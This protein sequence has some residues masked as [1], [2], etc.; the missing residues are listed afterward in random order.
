MRATKNAIGENVA[1]MSGAISGK[2]TDSGSCSLTHPHV[3]SLM[4]ATSNV[5][6]ESVA[7]MSG[8]TSGK[9]QRPRVSLTRISLRSWR[10]TNY[11]IGGN[12]ARM[13]GATSGNRKDPLVFVLLT[14]ISLR[15]CGRRNQFIRRIVGHLRRQGPPNRPAVNLLGRTD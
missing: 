4:R 8:A 12:V 2:P 10:A 5:I 14:R 9:P 11:A 1:R 6:G 15:S 3:A 13:S 7:R